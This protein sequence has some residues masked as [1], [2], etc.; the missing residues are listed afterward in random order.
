M[1]DARPSPDATVHRRSVADGI[2]SPL[3]AQNIYDDEAFF[4]AYSRLSRSTQGLA[5]APEWPT[6]RRLIGSVDGAR[7]VDLGCGYGWFCRWA[8]D[9]GASS[10]VGIDL[11]ERML[12][13][14]ASWP[15]RTGDEDR[16]HYERQDLDGLELH[17][18]SCDLV[19]SSL[20]MHYLVDLGHA[21]TTIRDALVGGGRLVFS[22]EHPLF[23]APTSPAFVSSPDGRSVWPLDRYLD[24]GPRTTDWLAPGVV[25]QHR[26][27]ATYVSALV[28]AGF[29]LT[30]LVEWG[31]DP[32]Q[33]AA[34]P[35]WAVERDRP[36]FLLIG[37]RRA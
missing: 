22:A 24:E 18:A 36:P 32:D 26:T 5:G 8:C 37:A 31:P 33:I 25:K 27:I 28:G 14:A 29:T 34:T 21:L 9:A 23:T 10:V 4:D 16:I 7:V 35:T 20:T 15:N 11:A 17:A 1:P 19:H 2:P 6:L 3:V 13:R 12:A 30:D